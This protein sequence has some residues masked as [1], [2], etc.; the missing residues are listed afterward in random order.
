MQKM[1]FYAD[2]FIGFDGLSISESRYVAPVLGGAK[3]SRR[4]GC[5][6]ADDPEVLYSP[7]L[8]Y[9]GANFHRAF[10]ALLQCFLGVE[11]LDAINQMRRH[12]TIRRRLR[13]RRCTGV[14]NNGGVEGRCGGAYRSRR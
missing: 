14:G 12:E 3:G 10:H 7:I 2:V 9:G 11:R 6:T 1:E 4:E 13:S 8:S 5:W